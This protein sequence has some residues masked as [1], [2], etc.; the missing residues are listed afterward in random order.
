MGISDDVRARV[1]YSAYRVEIC[2]TGGRVYNPATGKTH[3]LNRDAVRLLTC[4][5]GYHTLDEIVD[6]IAAMTHLG[7]A[8]VDAVVE[9]RL[10]DMAQDGLVWWRSERVRHF[11]IPAPDI[12]YMDLTAHCNLRCKHCGVAAGDPLSNELTT[13]EW[14]QILDQ[15]AGGGVR[16]VAISGGEP[17]LHPD[18]VDLMSHARDLGLMVE[19]STNGTLITPDLAN[20]LL[21]V[22]DHVQVSMDGA[23]AAVHDAFRGRKGAFVAAVRGISYLRQA[24]VPFMIGCV[25]HQDNLDDVAAVAGL[26]Y[27]LGAGSLRLIHFV[28]FGRGR[29]AA[30]LAL[31]HDQMRRLASDVR[32]LRRRMPI[33]ITEVNFEFLFEPPPSPEGDIRRSPIGCGGGWSSITITPQGEVLPCSFMA[34]MAGD[35]L[36]EKTFAEIWRHSRLLNYWRSLRVADIGG[37]CRACQW[38]SECRGGCPAANFAL[39][40]MFHPHVHCFLKPEEAQSGVP[41]TA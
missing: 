3:T 25:V 4:C 33:E 8:A 7:L 36:R 38:L 35:S 11:D 5:D 32:A 15:L 41:L 12:V 16:S 29:H 22:V 40:E 18:V 31:T 28:P 10:G 9:E 20:D 1:P 14:F 6:H 21:P 24:G 2:E 37:K 27:E 34:G 30:E 39:G 13:G 26:A 19:L 23:D 17:L